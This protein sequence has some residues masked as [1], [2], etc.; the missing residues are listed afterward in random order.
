MNYGEES[1]STILKAMED[2]KDKLVIIFAGYKD[3]MENFIRA[4]VGLASRIGYKINF[5]DYTLEELLQ[6]FINL[7][8]NNNLEITHNAKEKVKELIKESKKIE[9][10]GNARYINSLF[11]KVLINHA[12]NID[13]NPKD[14]IYLID[15]DDINPEMLANDSNKRKIGF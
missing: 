9:N 1:I 10:F 11:Q 7:L 13:K 3:E 4:N 8:K 6:I 12:K 5:K 14:N 2:Y 15:E